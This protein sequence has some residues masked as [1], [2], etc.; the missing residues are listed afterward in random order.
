MHT[1]NCP[2]CNDE[3]IQEF[4]NEHLCPTNPVIRPEIPQLKNPHKCPKCTLEFFCVAEHA[5][6]LKAHEIAE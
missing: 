3:I 6:H 2:L 1:I 4:A 5:D